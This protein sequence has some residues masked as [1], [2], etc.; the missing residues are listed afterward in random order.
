MIETLIRALA[1]SLR[2]FSDSLS[3]TS[4]SQAT[5]QTT[6]SATDEVLYRAM[7]ESLEKMARAQAETTRT[8]CETILSVLQGRPTEERT[9]RAPEVET[10]LSP[11]SSPDDLGPLPAG[12]EAIIAREEQESARRALLEERE[13]LAKQ[14]AD[15]RTAF[16][17]Q[18]PNGSGT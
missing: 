4:S 17:R 7:T 14:L 11:P 6:S 16:D 10:T 13:R 18:G 9:S 2:T 15:A 8:F 1:R 12:I 5:P 3:S